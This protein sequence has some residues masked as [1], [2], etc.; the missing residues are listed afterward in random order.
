MITVKKIKKLANK[1]SQDLTWGY[2]R[3]K[4]NPADEKIQHIFDMCDRLQRFQWWKILKANRWL[5]FIQGWLWATK[6]FSIEE[7]KLHNGREEASN[8]R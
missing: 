8:V 3:F 5:G 2:E 6:V 4:I 1:Y 7:M